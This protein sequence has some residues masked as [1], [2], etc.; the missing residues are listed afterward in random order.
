MAFGITLEKKKTCGHP[1]RNAGCRRGHWCWILTMDSGHENGIGRR[2]MNSPDWIHGSLSSQLS[3]APKTCVSDIDLLSGPFHHLLTCLMPALLLCS[4]Y[5]PLRL[6]LCKLSPSPGSSS[7]PSSPRPHHSA[8]IILFSSWLW[9]LERKQYD[10][11]QNH[12]SSFVLSMMPARWPSL[13][14]M[15]D[16]WRP[17]SD[18]NRTENSRW[19]P[20]YLYLTQAHPRTEQN[21]VLAEHTVT[22][23]YPMLTCATSCGHD[24]YSLLPWTW[25]FCS[26]EC[27]L[28]P[29]T[30]IALGTLSCHP[31]QCLK[32]IHTG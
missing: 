19:D 25:S 24:V 23:S 27:I 26:C 4:S 32:R 20:D 21:P 10:S 6:Q 11:S 17:F 1:G 18:H 9:H 2:K 15:L 8:S 7:I 12:P 16:F 22:Q 30:G 14:T 29:E 28:P 5:A 13:H 31:S 3:L